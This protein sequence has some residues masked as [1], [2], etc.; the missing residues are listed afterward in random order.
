MKRLRELEA[1]TPLMGKAQALIES[2]DAM[3]ESQERMERI[4]RQLDQRRP[5]AARLSALGLAALVALFGASAFAAVRIYDAVLAARSAKTSVT[6]RAVPQ[7]RQQRTHRVISDVPA[8]ATTTPTQL[9]APA[10]K[11]TSATAP[12]KPNARAHVGATRGEPHAGPEV[13]AT[14]PPATASDSELVHRAVKALRRDHD[15]ALAA[16]LLEDH[17]TRNPEGPLAEEALSLQIE[18]ASALRDARAHVLAR[19]YLTRYPSGRYLN[20]AKRALGEAGP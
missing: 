17:R 9:A 1:R 10:N 6:P 11:P 5:S 3:P 14:L 7:G 18:A 20:V 4:R 19:E 12:S 13:K 16:R 15:P 2:V 8:Q